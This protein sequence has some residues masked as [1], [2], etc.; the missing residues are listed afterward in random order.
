MIALEITLVLS[1]SSARFF[2]I[3]DIK[4]TVDVPVEIT[5]LSTTGNIENTVNDTTLLL[6][7]IKKY[8]Y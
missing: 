4:K 2:N 1:I 7:K 3:E 8:A 5:I 6:L